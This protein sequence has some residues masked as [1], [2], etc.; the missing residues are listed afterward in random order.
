MLLEAIE[1][2]CSCTVA[3]ITVGHQHWH[4]A[5]NDQQKSKVG[6]L[7]YFWRLKET[8]RICA[9]PR[10]Q[11]HWRHSQWRNHLVLRAAVY[12]TA[13][14]PLSVPPTLKLPVNDRWRSGNHGRRGAAW[15]VRWGRLWTWRLALLATAQYGRTWSDQLARAPCDVMTYRLMSTEVESWSA[16]GQPRV[17]RRSLTDGQCPAGRPPGRAASRWLCAVPTQVSPGD[18]GRAHR[19][20]GVWSKGRRLA[21][22]WCCH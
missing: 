14:S 16:A 7:L 13:P 10:T 2:R 8:P 21:S 1:Q 3:C 9:G 20:N 5:R 6:M 17:S 18:C 19:G 12:V 15:W 11:Q 4:A 22:R